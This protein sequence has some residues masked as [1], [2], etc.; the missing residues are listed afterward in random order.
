MQELQ[1]LVNKDNQ[2]VLS[3]SDNR[4]IAICMSN[5][6]LVFYMD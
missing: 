5:V 6:K 1:A 2:P 4:I 3:A